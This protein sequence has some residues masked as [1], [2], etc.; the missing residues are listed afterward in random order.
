MS[1]GYI[2]PKGAFGAE[3]EG[4]LFDLMLEGLTQEQANQRNALSARMKNQKAWRPLEEIQYGRG[5]FKTA[6]SAKSEKEQAK[7]K[8]STKK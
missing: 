2:H 4:Q 8:L 1:G 6:L 5:A 7:R 3:F